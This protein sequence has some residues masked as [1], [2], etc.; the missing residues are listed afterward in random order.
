[1]KKKVLLLSWIFCFFVFDTLYAQN[2]QGRTLKRIAR[3]VTLQL[4][5]DSI[6]LIHAG[7]YAGHELVA[8]RNKT[9]MVTHLGLKLFPDEVRADFARVE[10]LDFLERYYLEVISEH[11]TSYENKLVDDKVFFR[12]GK[13]SDF[14]K[15]G[16]KNRFAINYNKGSYYEA[17]WWNKDNQLIIDMIF[18]AR[19]DILTGLSQEEMQENF[20]DLLNDSILP[21]TSRTDTSDVIPTDNGLLTTR[22]KTYY[23]KSFTNQKY[24]S[25]NSMQ[26]VFDTVYVE[27]SAANLM[28]GIVGR[29]YLLTIEQAMY[30]FQTK[31]YTIRLNQWL[32]YC[33]KNHLETFFAVEEVRKD[34]IKALLI[35]RNE[36]LGY[37]HVMS[38]IFP[39]DFITKPQTALKAKLNIFV[40]TN[41]VKNLFSR[42]DTKNR[43]GLK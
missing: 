41:N 16:Y 20:R 13:L 23:L 43:R 10:V 30:G 36:P 15:I 39:K 5:K 12:R 25:P 8:Y 29:D 27:Q 31:K 19:I 18:P 17:R 34:G 6:G 11:G 40:P 7:S 35:T 14:L 3:I 24:Y 22:A 21:P 32:T 2:F 26:P 4:P 38:I 9:G 37:N 28:Q 1:M 42:Y 33:A